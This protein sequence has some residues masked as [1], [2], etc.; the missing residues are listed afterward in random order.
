MT[1]SDQKIELAFWS[2]VKVVAECISGRRSR[3]TGRLI[4]NERGNG[5]VA[6]AVNT[7]SLSNN[8]YFWEPLT[9]L[10]IAGI[11]LRKHL[12]TRWGIETD[13][14]APETDGTPGL[15]CGQPDRR[16]RACARASSSDK[17][18]SAIISTAGQS[19]TPRRGKTA[20]INLHCS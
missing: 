16:A 8:R 3:A 11:V 14:S 7:A 17:Q 13:P 15:R 12:H 4:E 20:A 9:Q 6:L 19:D 5:S 10:K 1:K 18:D 2:S